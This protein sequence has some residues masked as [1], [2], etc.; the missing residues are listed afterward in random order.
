MSST[1]CASFSCFSASD[2][3]LSTERPLIWDKSPQSF[4]DAEEKDALKGENECF[5]V[6]SALSS[7][8][9][10]E[11]LNTEE[12]LRLSRTE[13]GNNAEDQLGYLESRGLI[14]KSGSAYEI[15]FFSAYL[16]ARNIS[17]FNQLAGKQVRI[18]SYDGNDNLSPVIC[19]KEFKEG[20]VEAFASVFKEVIRLIPRHEKIDSE[21]GRRLIEFSIPQAVIREALSNA[22]AHQ[23]LSSE[24][25]EILIEIYKNRVEI[26]NSGKPV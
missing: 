2:I 8:E 17:D 18:I 23:D 14:K 3:D 15:P 10:L 4:L 11:L 5:I 12:Y 22:F 20:I 7:S 6:A 9:V 13:I 19:D 26:T 25:D 1:Q 24:G 21:S 16:L